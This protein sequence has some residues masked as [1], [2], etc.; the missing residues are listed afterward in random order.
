MNPS[1]EPRVRNILA[2]LLSVPQ[3][4]ITAESSPETLAS[5]DSIQHLNFVLSVEQEFGVAFRPEEIESINSVRGMIDT[6][7]NKLTNPSK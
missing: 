3:E 7:E 6:L 2:D 5:W 1:I 4:E